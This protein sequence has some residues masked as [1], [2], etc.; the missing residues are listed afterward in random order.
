MPGD[1]TDLIGEEAER[2]EE[3]E[4]ADEEDV[5]GPRVINSKGSKRK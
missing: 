1:V 2:E 4:E 5:E 3:E